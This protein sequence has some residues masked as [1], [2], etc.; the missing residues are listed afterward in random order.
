MNQRA[1]TDFEQLL[2]GLLA[3]SPQSGYE[4]KRFFAT[5]PAI[6]YQPSSGA[7]Y[8][9]LRRLEQ[10]GLLAS[11]QSP[12]AGQR[13]QRRYRL[14][15]TGQATHLAWL[16]RPVDSGTVAR[17]LGIHLMRFVMAEPLLAPEEIF[18]LLSDLAC[19]LET[20]IA[21]TDRYLDATPLPGRHPRLAL[22]HGIE[23]HR[24]SLA[25]ARS[26]IETLTGSDG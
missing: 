23:V 11:D 22:L 25:W 20:F 19:A 2:L 10:R 16:R 4:L 7:L 6:A 12:S 8:P 21:D 9:A 3:R 14:T 17:D 13:T 1:P 26:A 18:K 5:T 15:L 24:A